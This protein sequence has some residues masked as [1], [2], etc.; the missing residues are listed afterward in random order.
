MDSFQHTPAPSTAN[1]VPAQSALLARRRK[2]L[3]SR[4]HAARKSPSTVDPA[5]PEVISS[6]ISSLSTIS[7]PVQSHFD[8]VP[9]IDPDIPSAPSFFQTEFSIPDPPP[10]SSSNGP[11]FGVTYGAQKSPG[12]RPESPY[13]HPDDAA[14]APVVRMA[15][16][17]PSPKVKATFDPPAS[18]IRPTSK[19]SYTSTRK[20]YEGA[21][22]GI[23]SA[24]PPPPPI[25][26]APSIASSSSEGR[27]SLKDALG[28]L[29]KTSRGSINDKERKA[30]Q[31]RKTTSYSDTMKYNV[32]RNRA[33]IR[34]MYSMVDAA[35]RPVSVG[36]EARTMY[37][38]SAPPSRD[39]QSLQILKEPAPGGIGSGRTIPARESSL[40]NS[41]SPSSKY[42]RSTRHRRY[43][44]VG[45]K[46]AKADKI[47]LEAD[48]NE[49]E[50]VTKRIQQ[51]KD[52]QQ[53][54]KSELET[55]NTP[56]KATRAAT[57]TPV[58]P[59]VP[60]QKPSEV[61]QEASSPAKT[62]A[63][64]DESA[65]APAV[66]TG[67]SRTMPSTGTP[68]L[69]MTDQPQSKSI[70]ESLDKLD[71]VDKLRH[72]QSL[73]PTTPTKRHKRSPS[74]PTSPARVSVAVDRPSSVDSVDVAVSDYVSSPKLTQRIPHPTTGRMIAFSEV[75]DPKG[76]VVLCCLGMGL[77]RYLMAFYDE[78][79]RTLKLR[80][81]TLDRPGVGESEPY[82]DETGTP[83][84]WPGK[85][86]ILQ[87]WF[88]YGS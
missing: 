30:D 24:E 20:A 86:A 3:P 46:D 87:K 66:L 6:L 27:R 7:V 31:V 28:L 78:L 69:S 68:L 11:G 52:Q 35:E 48:N 22:F 45:S 81:I 4:A 85:Y 13:L 44:S 1:G 41:F 67:K 15:R 60:S 72:R 16:A 14:D 71:Q 17:Q 47:E 5:S 62:I 61:R 75:G 37:A 53:K 77:T 76:H 34:S 65:P 12:E 58:E 43:S 57:E 55:D 19:G 50:Q 26:A 25:S 74:G 39:N 21:A 8:N 84:G 70:R 82:M 36:M 2:S 38:V 80:L 10:S 29:R 59:P 49:A 23:I 63:V 18:P 54:I 88:G 83:L 33:S 56:A 9:P 42:H 79:A 73:E 32:P 64:V 40:R 51:L